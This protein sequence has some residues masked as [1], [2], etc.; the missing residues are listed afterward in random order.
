MSVMKPLRISLF[1]W[2][3]RWQV[4]PA[5]LHLAPSSPCQQMSLRIQF[6]PVGQAEIAA[7]C[8]QKRDVQVLISA[9]PFCWCCSSASHLVLLLAAVG[10]LC[11]PIQF[12]K[13]NKEK[14]IGSRKWKSL[15]FFFFCYCISNLCDLVRQKPWTKVLDTRNI[16]VFSRRIKQSLLLLPMF[17]KVIVSKLF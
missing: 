13:S 6:H 10:F 8:H 1:L 3:I 11:K 15:A 2:N 5:L 4:V 7:H 12:I 16:W 17:I 9:L 14:N